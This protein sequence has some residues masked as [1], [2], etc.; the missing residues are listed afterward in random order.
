MHGS[1]DV[2][3]LIVLGCGHGACADC[4]RGHL[5]AQR[6]ITHAVFGFTKC[7]QAPDCQFVVPL[8]LFQAFLPDD[9]FQRFVH[10]TVKRFQLPQHVQ[11]CP[12]GVCIVV[13]GPAATTDLVTTCACVA[14]NGP[15]HRNFCFACA[16]EHHF[17]ISCNDAAK[18]NVKID[19]MV[20][21]GASYQL[22]CLTSVVLSCCAPLTSTCTNF[23][24]FSLSLSL[25]K[26]M[27]C[28][29]VLVTASIN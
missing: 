4:W 18:W 11:F 20:R 7:P 28:S 10:T 8:P 24:C 6:D 14:A 12:E 13:K 5:T 3:P 2:V 25:A 21:T 16:I 15:R 22:S 29:L 23:R 17:P 1:D 19:E 26:N 27:C 9:E